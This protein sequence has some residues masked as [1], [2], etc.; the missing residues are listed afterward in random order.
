MLHFYY[1]YF[2]YKSTVVI[3]QPSSLLNS[4]F[5]NLNVILTIKFIKRNQFFVVV[6]VIFVNDGFLIYL[7]LHYSKSF[8]KCVF[9]TTPDVID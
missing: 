2:V 4:L 8:I 9:D 5:E 7:Q 1:M 6:V 3:Q